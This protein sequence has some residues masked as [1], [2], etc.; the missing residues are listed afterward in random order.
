MVFSDSKSY[1][2]M[3][4]MRRDLESQ[5]PANFGMPGEEHTIPDQLKHLITG[6]Q[7]ENQVCLTIFHFA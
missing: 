4:Q 6:L 2:M 5:L 1:A 3:F 7:K